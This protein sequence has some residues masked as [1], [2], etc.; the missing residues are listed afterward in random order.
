MKEILQYKN[1]M[2]NDTYIT[3]AVNNKVSVKSI[4]PFNKEASSAVLPLSYE[5]MEAKIAEWKTTGKHVQDVFTTLNADEREFLMTGI[6]I[7]EW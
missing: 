1:N 4:S 3:H 6:P 5:T 2:G 7:W